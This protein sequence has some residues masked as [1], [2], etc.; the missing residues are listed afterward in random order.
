MSLVVAMSMQRHQIAQ[1]VVA[2]QGAWDPVVDFD[3]RL[4]EEVEPTV[5]TFALL[6]GE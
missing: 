3:V 6:S 4:I 5:A 2:A 1:L